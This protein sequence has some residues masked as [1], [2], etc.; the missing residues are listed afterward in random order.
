MYIEGSKQKT[1]PSGRL[2]IYPAFEAIYKKYICLHMDVWNPS[3][4][5]IKL[6]IKYDQ[7]TF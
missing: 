6:K 5:I 3:V 2:N 7:G 1:E 4:E